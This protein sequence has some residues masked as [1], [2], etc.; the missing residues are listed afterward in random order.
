[1]NAKI[2]VFLCDRWLIT[3]IFEK[4]DLKNILKTREVCK[5]WKETVD[6]KKFWNHIFD[7]NLL[8]RLV[9][10]KHNKQTFFGN[11]YDNGSNLKIVFGIKWELL[12]RDSSGISNLG[13]IIP[14]HLGADVQHIN[15]IGGSIGAY[16]FD[17]TNIVWVDLHLWKGGEVEEIDFKSVN[18][19][20]PKYIRNV[21]MDNMYKSL[22]K[23][24]IDYYCIFHKKLRLEELDLNY[25]IV[26]N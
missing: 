19:F 12:R 10:Y 18:Y 17:L 26:K 4:M 11:D 2:S 13:F 16:G 5:T 14:T 23:L 22:K 3:C 25:Y 1:M 8:D 24:F 15:Y 21:F 9:S 7:G 6:H 20:F